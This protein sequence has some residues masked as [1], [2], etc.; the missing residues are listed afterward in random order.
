[1]LGSAMV[2]FVALCLASAF[3]EGNGEYTF[4][5]GFKMQKIVNGL[6]FRPLADFFSK[7]K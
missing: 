3:A 2:V 7:T 6:T 5:D 4:S 1:M